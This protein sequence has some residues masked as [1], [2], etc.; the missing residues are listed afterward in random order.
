[1]MNANR[2][3]APQTMRAKDLVIL[4]HSTYHPQ[5]RPA[6]E[7]KLRAGTLED[8][9]E[10]LS[11][12]VAIKKTLNEG[13]SNT[14]DMNISNGSVGDVVNGWNEVKCSFI[15]VVEILVDGVVSSE[16]I[17]QGYTD[18]ADFTAGSLT[19]GS[20]VRMNPDTVMYMNRVM[21]IVYKKDA[22]TGA[23]RPEFHGA[24]DIVVNNTNTVG[25]SLVRPSDLVLGMHNDA[26]AEDSNNSL[27]VLSNAS[28][29][30]LRGKTSRTSNLI[31]GRMVGSLVQQ[32][33]T[34]KVSTDIF[35]DSDNHISRYENMLSELTEIS[36]GNIT[37]LKLIGDYLNRVSVTSL[38]LGE[39]NRVF[40][41]L[42]PVISTVESYNDVISQGNNKTFNFAG[43]SDKGDST[44][45]DNQLTRGQK[46]ITAY[47][48]DVMMSYGYVQF[49]GTITNKTIDGSIYINHSLL[50]NISETVNRNP[51]L[52]RQVMNVFY[53]KLRDGETKAI[54]SGGVAQE[55]EL[56]FDLSMVD[57]IM[58]I[59][60][61]GNCTTI[62]IPTLC[63]SVM[64]PIIMD[65][66]KSD[67]LKSNLRGIVD[68]VLDSVESATI[69]NTVHTG[70]NW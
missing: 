52:G 15:L 38:T 48:F 51:V 14:M 3:T 42:A 43:I 59:N 32:A 1:M 9:N 69:S 63:D 18:K 66:N 16:E 50:N 29:H 46:R 27:T 39:L 19:A 44:L 24:R 57:S 12:N 23:I 34:S 28:E 20:T 60:I 47:L 22:A 30:S 5:I 13:L 53:E 35:F 41:S 58:S 11:G 17:Y 45:V 65:N 10:V 56:V 25:C 40:P 61:N 8:I 64:S 2:N 67:I 26:M 36:V 49:S 4:K 62:R 54:L 68:G 6:L 31:G 21:E 7:A 33:N 55:I 70:I 37:G